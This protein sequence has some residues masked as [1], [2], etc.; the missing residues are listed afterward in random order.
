MTKI[1]FQISILGLLILMFCGVSNVNAQ[2]PEYHYGNGTGS[3]VFPLNTTSSNKVQ[4]LYIN[5][6]FNAQPPAG[7]ISKIY[8]KRSNTSSNTSVFQNFTIK[9]GEIPATM[10]QF[11]NATFWTAG[12]VEVLSATTYSVPG[13]SA[14]S[15]VEFDLAVPFPYDG[16]SNL[17]VE[18]SQTSYTNGISLHN[19][20]SGTTN[21]RIWGPVGNTSGSVG[22]G[23]V[24][25]GFEMTYGVLDIGIEDSN[26]ESEI[27]YGE[28]QDVDLTIMN[29][30]DFQV[31]NFQVGWSI[32]NVLQ[33][34]Y[35]FTEFLD[36]IGGTLSHTVDVTLPGIDFPEGTSEVKFWTYLPN[37]E[38]DEEPINDTVSANVLAKSYLSTLDEVLC[39]GDTLFVG[40]QYF[41]SPLID[42]EVI[43][44]SVDGCDSVVV[45]NL[46]FG[47][48]IVFDWDGTI[49][50]MCEGEE[51]YI[52]YGHPN[53]AFYSWSTGATTDSIIVN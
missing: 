38:D 29:Y 16:V 1:Y 50:G 13:S 10:T 22:T 52:I 24:D 35:S 41:T 51:G 31:S 3:N 11:P 26:I 8:L 18:V 33:T 28:T 43:L 4:W 30:G 15:W 42:H 6:Q 47:P 37:N 20:G 23:P 12:M 9:I 17:V 19:V 44:T 39:E 45:V 2:T 40:N 32:D 14:G 53:A 34:P 5:N 7:L 49:G 48:E 27:C 21:R 36:T 46:D 25:F